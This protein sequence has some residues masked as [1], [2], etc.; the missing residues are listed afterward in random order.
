VSRVG[1]PGGSPARRPRWRLLARIALGIGLVSAV[2]LAVT[3]GQVYRA[4]RNDGARSAR[5]IV[6]LGAAQYDGRPSPVFRYRLDHALG[7]YEARYAARIVV[8]GGRQ[9]GD[10]FTEAEAGY[11]YLRDQGVP[12]EVLLREVAG[13]NT[14]ESLEEAAGFLIEQ[15]L[16][17]VVLVTDG[18]H[19]YRVRAI[20]EELGLDATVS[21]APDRLSRSSEL[22]LLLRETAAVSVGRLIGWNRLFRIDSAVND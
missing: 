10:R 17:D 20:A 8:T 6:V 7:L 16:T 4:S 15:G 13:S 18:Y 3:F 11:R 12:E 1:P 9:E 22:R 14:Y 2:Y 21:P 5:A 19:A